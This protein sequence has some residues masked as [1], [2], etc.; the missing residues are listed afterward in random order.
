MMIQSQALGILATAPW[1]CSR[2]LLRSSRVFL[3]R[4]PVAQRRRLNT[5][6]SLSPALFARARSLAT[7]HSTLSTRLADIF[8]TQIAR[9]AGELAPVAK[10]IKEWDDA[11]ESISELQTLLDDPDTDV[12]LRTLALE[13]LETSKRA[14]SVISDNLKQ[15][16]I[17]RHPFATLPCLLEIRPGAGGD[18]AGLFAFEVFRMYIA[19]CSH[20][21]FRSSV[22]K[23]EVGDGSAE[24]RL[25]EAVIE[26]ETD[27]AYD[28]LRTESGVHRVQRVPATETKGRTHTSAVSVMVLPSF[29]ETGGGPDGALN[30]EDPNNDY[31]V[32]PQEVRSEKM[33]AG[34]AGGQHVNKTESAIRL[35]HIPTGIAVS[36]QESRSQ[37]ANRKKAWQILRARLA[38][39]RQTAREQEMMEMRRGVLGGVARMGRGDKIRTYNYGQNR[40]TDHRSG[41][42]LHNLDGVLDGGD[43]LDTVMDSVRAWLVDQEVSA[44]AAEELAKNASKK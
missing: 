13:D 29:P 31:Y 15:A 37:H 17:P 42:T 5:S 11:N 35:T 34:G 20:R 38:E 44:M 6:A 2:C 3:G 39:A 19:F 27:G 9:R 22:M 7:E 4:W 30:I 16:L 36:M 21:G 40:C 43:G 24:D 18:E 32:D 8:D 12:E 28:V 10:S 33:R 14:L 1:V 25:S 23:L 41:I 26:V